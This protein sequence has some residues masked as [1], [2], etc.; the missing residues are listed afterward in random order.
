MDVT[1]GDITSAKITGRIEMEGS[2]NGIKINGEMFEGLPQNKKLDALFYNLEEQSSKQKKMAE[3]IK[4]I[5]LNLVEK[6]K[7]DTAMAGIC[8][9]LSSI[10]TTLITVYLYIKTTIKP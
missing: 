1:I 3:E 4:D 10:A 6:S 8:G 5:K 2:L 7:R 9:S